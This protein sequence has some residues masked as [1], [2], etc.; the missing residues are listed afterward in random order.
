MQYDFRFRR[1]LTVQTGPPF[2]STN[3]SLPTEL[4]GPIICGTGLPKNGPN[5]LSAGREDL[6]QI[7]NFPGHTPLSRYSRSTGKPTPTRFSSTGLSGGERWG[8]WWWWRMMVKSSVLWVLGKCETGLFLS[9]FI[10][11]F[12]DGDW[13]GVFCK[14]GLVSLFKMIW[15]LLDQV[16]RRKSYSA[17][18]SS[19]DF[20]LCRFCHLAKSLLTSSSIYMLLKML[21]RRCP[22]WRSVGWWRTPVANLLM[23]KNIAVHGQGWRVCARYK[24]RKNAA[25][26]A[27]SNENCDPVSLSNC[28]IWQCSQLFAAL[29]RDF[30]RAHLFQ[31]I[32]NQT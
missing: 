31:V 15:L 18:A 2:C 25:R 13:C 16:D 23:G 3:P 11:L 20:S 14:V 27:R 1:R 22:K 32:L 26:I 21:M 19:L 8:G 6:V 30:A 7:P 5:I 10:Y 9:W 17:A 12:L 29:A 24:F 28:P 4:S